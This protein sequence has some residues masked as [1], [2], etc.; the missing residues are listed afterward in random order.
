G[1]ENAAG[2]DGFGLER[3]SRLAGDMKVW[4]ELTEPARTLGGASRELDILNVRYLIARNP[5]FDFEGQRHVTPAAPP[6]P[7][8]T[9]QPT[10][11]PTPT[12][13]PTSTPSPTPTNPIVILPDG[14]ATLTDPLGFPPLVAGERL[15]FETPAVE[16]D[17]LILITN[18]SWATEVEDMTP[19][20]R[21]RLRSADGRLFEFDLLAGAH[22]SEW[23]Y[24]R[25]DTRANVKHSRAVVA[26]NFKV[27]DPAG[28]YD[29]YT[30][31]A[32]FN[33][34]REATITGGEIEVAR[35][36]NAPKLGVGVELINLGPGVEHYLRREQVRRIRAGATVE[37]ATTLPSERW[38]HVADEGPL[39]VYENTR[40]LPRAW[41]AGEAVA[42]ADDAALKT[43]RTGLLPDGRAWEPRT[44]AVVDAATANELAGAGLSGGGRAEVMR[45]EPNRVEVSAEADGA[46]LVVLADNHYPGWRA[47]LD[48]RSVE[49]L[50]VNY[51]QRG[52]VIPPGRH[53]VTFVY[54]PK[55]VL[56]G[57]LV[58]LLTAA[59]LAAWC[60]HGRRAARKNR[61]G[62][63]T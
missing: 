12:P 1:V 44:T 47:Y 60:A 3:Y 22:T 57:L 37:G 52:V 32:L 6:Q 35:I 30:Y 29:G 13:P 41:L 27:N 45:H 15:V 18:L 4:G 9:P 23:S 25:A 26:T 20:A 50:R 11:T 17:S 7:A 62:R 16:T 39:T 61:E 2:Y 51:N 24:E 42:L 19:V 5:R 38:R 40:S 46:A 36:G 21:V 59:A 28:D 53:I 54:R 58:S 56:F 48:G 55:S 33:L 63:H 34:P 31:L 14:R 49:T 10:P 8:P 43:I